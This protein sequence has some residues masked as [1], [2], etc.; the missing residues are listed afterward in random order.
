M[1]KAVL[2]ML[3]LFSALSLMFLSCSTDSSGGGSDPEFD[4]TICDSSHN[5]KLIWERESGKEVYIFVTSSNYLKDLKIKNIYDEEL[6]SIEFKVDDKIDVEEFRLYKVYLTGIPSEAGTYQYRLS[7]CSESNSNKK[8]T[9]DFTVKITGSSSDS[10]VA[11]PVITTQPVAGRDYYRAGETIGSLSVVARVSS[12]ELSY[13][14]YKDGNIINDATG[15][16]YTPTEKGE[17]YVVVSNGSGSDKKS[18]KS[19]VVSIVV[20]ADG[21]LPPPT[22]TANLE[23]SVSY[24]KSSMIEAIKVTATASEGTVHAAWYCDGVVVVSDDTKLSYTPTKFGAYYCKLW[25]EK[26]GNKSQTITS[27]TI[28]I[29]ESEISITINGLDKEAY[30]GNTLTVSVVTNVDTED[31]LYQWIKASGNVSS[32]NDE[33]ITGATSDSYKPTEE[34]YYTCRV[35]VKSKGGQ[36]KSSTN[37]GICHVK[38][39]VDGDAEKPVISTQPKDVSCEAGGTITLAVEVETP[40]DGGKL[41]YQWKKDGQSISGATEATYTKADVTTEDAGNYTVD[42]TNTLSTGKSATTTS[43]VAKVSVSGGTG[44]ID[45]GIFQF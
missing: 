17:Y 23:E 22:I 39:Q 32:S 13:Q 34:G 38:K 24:D 36:E 35:T 26:D 44:N 11:M 43:S 3:S 10:T 19:D 42:V 18:V 8:K 21:E 25:A 37:G 41:S 28:T 16:T 20:L 7:V 5:E 14:W 30:L 15:A 31:I 40:A 6:N 29:K 45:G 12:G 27:K 2:L 1:K 33:P 4:V 9:I